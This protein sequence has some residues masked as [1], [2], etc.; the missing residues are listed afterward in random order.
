[1][2]QPSTSDPTQA[3][4]PE[5]DKMRPKG[6]GRL[7]ASARSHKVASV[8]IAV[9]GF[10]GLGGIFGQW[11]VSQLGDAVRGD[12]PPKGFNELYAAWRE[13]AA[14]N[15]RL[16]AAGAEA[17]RDLADGTSDTLRTP[18]PELQDDLA[19]LRAV[20]GDAGDLAGRVRS[21]ATDLPG[22]RD[23]LLRLVAIEETT[24][25]RVLGAT[26][27]AYAEQR[28]TPTGGGSG[29]FQPIYL[30]SDE[31]RSEA[32]RHDSLVRQV[33][34]G[35]RLHARRFHRPEPKIRGWGRLVYMH[36]SDTPSWEAD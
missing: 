26:L 30:F 11:A 25:N 17:N 7:A 10:L 16:L 12:T 29:G 13:T 9:V 14:L 33:A 8:L 5:R 3:P 15:E 34:A 2:G 1:M 31:L 4:P 19:D 18:P 6:R 35:L 36:V 32:V 27:A 22:A 21:I 28:G 23:D 20:R 24:A